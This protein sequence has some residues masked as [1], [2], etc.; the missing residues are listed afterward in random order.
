MS[1]ILRIKI[2]VLPTVPP[3]NEPIQPPSKEKVNPVPLPRRI[4]PETLERKKR[5]I[6]KTKRSHPEPGPQ[7]EEGSAFVMQIINSVRTSHHTPQE[8][9]AAF[10]NRNSSS[11][12]LYKSEITV[13]SPGEGSSSPPS[14]AHEQN[15]DKYDETGAA[16]PLL[17]LSA[18]NMAA[19]LVSR[20]STSVPSRASSEMVEMSHEDAMVETESSEDDERQVAPL[21]RSRMHRRLSGSHG[22][23]PSS[24]LPS[25]DT[26]SPPSQQMVPP[27]VQRASLTRAWPKPL[28]PVP[29]AVHPPPEVVETKRPE[30]PIPHDT[31]GK[32]GQSQDEEPEPTQILHHVCCF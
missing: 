28:S 4:A 2:S 25:N 1:F 16:E 8:I 21:V 31:S 20:S 14:S 18:K 9:L 5:T 7:K 24:D 32:A 30:S 17:E 29:V 22:S 13:Q 11:K 10:N 23:K 26:P 6:G 19:N 27:V 12:A 3:P 15:G